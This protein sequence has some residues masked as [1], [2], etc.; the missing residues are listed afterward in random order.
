LPGKIHLHRSAKLQ[1]QGQDFLDV[2]EEIIGRAAEIA[3]IKSILRSKNKCLLTLTG[4]GGSGKTTLARTIADECREEFEDGVFFVELASI[5][6]AEH[7]AGAIAQV[8]DLKESGDR[9]LLEALKDF[10]RERASLLVLDNFEQLLPAAPLVKELLDSALNLKILVTSRA[11]LHLKAEQEK[12]VL[13][14]AVPP[15]Y[16]NL[17]VEQLYGYASIELFA[18]RARE[19][20]PNFV[21]NEE[22]A[23]VISEI[24]NRLDGLPLAIELAAARVKLLSPRAILERLENSLKLL[25][26]GAGELPERQRTMR[27]TIRWSCDLLAEAE[28]DLFPRLAVFAGGFTV[29]SAEAVCEGCETA[30]KHDPAP[31]TGVLDSL[32]TLVD[33]NL[34][35]SKE[36][37]D[38]NAR[39]SMLEVVREFALE[40]FQKL[41]DTDSCE[42]FTPGFLALA[43]EAETFLQDEAGNKWLDKLESEHDNLCGALDWSLK[44]DPQTAARIAA[45]LRFFWSNH[46]H[47]SEGLRWSRAA[48][49]TTENSLSEARSKLLMSN[50]LFLKNHGDLEAARKSYEKCLSESR[51]TNDSVHI[52]KAN[53]GLAAVAVLQ[54]DIAA[55]QDFLTEAL[56]LSLELGDAL[57]TAHSLGSFGDLEMCRGNLPAARRLLEECLALSKKLGSE[58]IS[59]T[60]Y[61]NLGTI[62]YLETFY[63]SAAY[64]FA[65]SL[66]IAEEMGNKTM[67][68]CALDGFAALAAACGNH[69]Q[70]TRLAGAGAA[71][72][73]EIG[74]PLEPAEESFREKYLA[75]TR[76]VLNEKEAALL[77]EEG[78][79]MNLEEAVILAKR[80]TNE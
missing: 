22:N 64:N 73:E 11:A 63:E 23:S 40:Q 80:T 36:Q 74:C 41:D 67:I 78:R 70:S 39:L 14:L 50:G 32:S 56:A 12:V 69:E 59:T 20:K 57:Q 15:Q 31:R 21:L 65:E 48:L 46:S 30:D 1:N 75:K 6:R 77:Y 8:F 72:R 43:E 60:V 37:A 76:V 42:K 25:T 34:L 49:H 18:V 19:T 71:L 66:R 61:F 55:A 38:R 33:S 47:L 4:A 26:G 62:D 16:S 29:E 58:R 7:V 9:S 52:V 24:C 13:P 2:S 53:H 17:S 51:E 79:A 10:L 3:E 45:A 54:G 68:A 44:N 5:D 35:V 27:D 28:K